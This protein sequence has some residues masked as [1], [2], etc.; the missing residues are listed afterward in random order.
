MSTQTIDHQTLELR[1][2]FPVSRERLFAAWTDPEEFRQWF[3]P[4]S[5]RVLDVS[6]DVRVGG[7][8]VV[9]IAGEGDEVMKNAGEFREVNPPSRLVYTWGWA[10]DPDWDGVDSIVTVDFIEQP[11]GAEVRVS[12]QRFPSAE[13]RGRHEYGWTGALENLAA[14]VAR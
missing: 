11:G 9:T 1:R 2:T 12:H 6:M 5:C 3:G 10:N 7:R 8:Y 13:S 14:Y 4:D